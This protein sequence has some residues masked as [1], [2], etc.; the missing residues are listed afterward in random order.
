MR[1]CNGHLSNKNVLSNSL[2][3]VLLREESF[4]RVIEPRQISTLSGFK[5]VSAEEIS[6]IIGASPSKHCLLDPAPTWFIKQLL[7]DL[8]ET[9]AKMCNMSLEEGI[10]PSS[11]KSTI[12][13]P[14]LKKT[15]L[16][17]ED[18]NSI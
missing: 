16:D 2:K 7:P 14:R 9:I 17:P 15:N 13:R 12:V 5:P 11:L 18:L 1:K 3:E 4:N 6:K 10:F 8:A